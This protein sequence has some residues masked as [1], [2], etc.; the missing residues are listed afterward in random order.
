VVL[1]AISAS[2]R[3]W[4]LLGATTYS[5]WAQRGAGCTP[6]HVLGL[7]CTKTPLAT[8]LVHQRENSQNAVLWNSA[9]CV[10]KIMWPGAELCLTP[11]VSRPCPWAGLE[12]GPFAVKRPAGMTQNSD[13]TNV[14][15]DIDRA[16]TRI[17]RVAPPPD[18][19]RSTK[20][21]HEPRLSTRHRV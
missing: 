8:D 11:T 21:P 16:R 3:G 12:G 9:S 15:G 10:S 14:F 4:R 20:G 13:L 2:R 5:P 1:G 7:H 6:A 17:R 18:L 19:A